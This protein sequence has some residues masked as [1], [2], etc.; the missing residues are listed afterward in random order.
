MTVFSS[1]IVKRTV[2]I[3]L[4][5]DGG[6]FGLSVE[7]FQLDDPRCSSLPKCDVTPRG[8]FVSS[9]DGPDSQW[10]R[11]TLA[12]PK[13]S[14]R[15]L[16]AASDFGENLKDFCDGFVAPPAV[17]PSRRQYDVGSREDMIQLAIRFFGV[18]PDRLAHT[19]AI[20]N[21]LATPP[22]KVVVRT[23]PIYKLFPQGRLKASK[24]P[25]VSKGRVGNLKHATTAEVVCTDTFETGDSRFKYCQVFYDLVSRWG[26]VFRCT[27][28]PR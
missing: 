6:L 4:Q 7:P 24:T 2:R 23:P 11:R 28:R 16:I 19:V 5:L 13:G 22:Y 10:V 15:A 12:E 21:G 20:A 3:P 26:W 27:P 9:D 1:G 14:G 8:E 18:G 17:P 25:F